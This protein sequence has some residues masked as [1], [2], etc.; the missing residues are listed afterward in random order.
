[1]TS[2]AADIISHNGCKICRFKPIP[3]CYARMTSAQSWSWRHH[4]FEPTSSLPIFKG[5]Y[6]V[7]YK[8]LALIFPVQ[9]KEC[10]SLY[11]CKNPSQNRHVYPAK[12]SRFES[13]DFA[14]VMIDDVSRRCHHQC[15]QCVYRFPVLTSHFRMENPI[16]V[17][18]HH[19]IET[20]SRYSHWA[21]M[22]IPVMVYFTSL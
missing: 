8:T 7:I 20:V 16:W 14:S 5:L 10:W 6:R 19:Y 15:P 12:S 17:K 21:L 2:A 18:Q 22:G 1:M 3:F 11:L 4:R 13:I 9:L